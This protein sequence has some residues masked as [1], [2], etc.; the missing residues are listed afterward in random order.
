M[1]Q[2]QCKSSKPNLWQSI[3]GERGLPLLGHSLDFLY[4]PVETA[5]KF[6]QKYGPIFK[7]SI[8]GI[9]AVVLIGPEANKLVLMD[10]QN[11]FSNGKGWEFFI[12][13]FFK[14]G[15][16]LLDFDEHRLHR[17]IMQ[18][19]F[20]KAAMKDYV[21]QMNPVI[22]YS[23]LEWQRKEEQSV[24]N[25]LP[26]IKQLTLNIA[27]QVFMG[28]RLGME[29]D[30]I[31]K[32]F[33]DCVRAGTALLRYPIPGGRWKKGI[34]SRKILESF[35][36]NKIDKKRSNPGA[37]LFSWICSAKDKNGRR[38]TNEDVVNHMIF[39]MMAAH[40]TTTLTLC[41][42]FYY[43]AKHPEWQT[44]LRQ[45]SLALRKDTLEYTD[46]EYL[47]GIELVMKES[48]R[49]MPPVHGIPRYTVKETEFY[50]NVIPK[51][52]FV[53]ISPYVTHRMDKYWHNP[54]SFDPSRFD[55]NQTISITD[56]FQY[57]PFGGGAHKCI[58]LHFAELQI[59]TIM[60][61]ILLNYR[62]SV[63]EGYTMPI[64]FTT[65]PTPKD[66]LPLKLEHLNNK[67]SSFSPS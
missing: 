26:H 45:Q 35:I 44:R 37:D 63:P 18:S 41:A 12:G 22:S 11:A 33:V 58:G 20:K 53:I 21:A 1:K 39:L 67:F 32:A 17:G 16:M 40:D 51:N 23:Q 50:G 62:W 64:N 7:V 2:T 49:L 55:A 27:T 9:P 56:P 19:A 46:L 28:E 54:E 38:F 14:R 61:Q 48:L 31:N 4:R 34:N 15:I 5:L 29:A 42:M 30:E 10:R 3:P 60:H 8:F 47:I 65:L 43:L 59:K 52:T 25:A 13:K 66:N 6:E 57:I 36:R 24:F